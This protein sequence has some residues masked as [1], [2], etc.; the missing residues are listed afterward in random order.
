MPVQLDAT[1]QYT[2][3]S[4]GMIDAAKSSINSIM[5]P[6]NRD[7]VV[8]YVVINIQTTFKPVYLATN[9]K[10]YEGLNDEYRAIID[11]I[12]GLSFSLERVRSFFTLTKLILSGK[13]SRSRQINSMSNGS[14]PRTQNPQNEGS[15][16]TPCKQSSTTM[17]NAAFRMPARSA[18]H[19][20]NN[21]KTHGSLTS[22]AS[23]I[24]GESEEHHDYRP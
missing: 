12:S 14:S 15:T 19:Q 11:K 18:K 23:V 16:P 24:L 17:Q 9:K 7:K 22:R 13:T 4:T 8:D 20:T 6:W 1:E 5:P 21:R 2:L 3:L 10:R